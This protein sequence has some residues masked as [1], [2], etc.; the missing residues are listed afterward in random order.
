MDG[1]ITL[2]AAVE[3]YPMSRRTLFYWMKN[4]SVI[5]RVRCGSRQVFEADVAHRCAV[6]SKGKRKAA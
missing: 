1:Y 2:A 5:F 6:M 4:G 3:R